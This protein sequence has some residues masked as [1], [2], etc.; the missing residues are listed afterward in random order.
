MT[1]LPVGSDAAL[2]PVRESMLET[3][4][5]TADSIRST[6]RKQ[7][8]SIMAAAMEEA[9]RIRTTAITEGEAAARSEA[10]LRSAGVRRQAHET[11]LTRRNALRLEVLRQVREAS[12]ALRD[13]PRY[14][15]LVARL[16]AR[17]HAQ[18]GPDATVT[19]SPD[20]GIIAQAG[21][22]RLD[23]SL[24]ILAALTLESMTPEVSALW[25][26]N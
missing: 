14:P 26:A 22:R 1:G 2:A 11:V 24:P 23:L 16:T 8:Q 20:G 6:A 25:E 13:D 10:A 7:A 17:S 9:E 21:S 19:E 12:V 18:L 5:A 3:A 15:D 4:R